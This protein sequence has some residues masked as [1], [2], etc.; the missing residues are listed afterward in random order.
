MKSDYSFTKGIGKGVIF[1][2]QALATIVVIT[3]LSDVSI[4]D[5]IVQYVKPIV[6]TLT[7][8]GVIAVATNYVKYNWLS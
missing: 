7:V 5:L 4:W 8:G 6:G 1:M 2:L 3:G